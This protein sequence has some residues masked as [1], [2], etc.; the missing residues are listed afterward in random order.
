MLVVGE[1]KKIQSLFFLIPYSCNSILGAPLN[2]DGL[3][4]GK[5]P[6]PNSLL[7][8]SATMPTSCDML[9]FE[10]VF[11]NEIEELCKPVR[12]PMG[13]PLSDLVQFHYPDFRVYFTLVDLVIAMKRLFTS[14]EMFDNNNLSMIICNPDFERAPNRRAFRIQDIR[15]VLKPL[16]QPGPENSIPMPLVIPEF[17]E[18]VIIIGSALPPTSSLVDKAYP[19]CDPTHKYTISPELREAFKNNKFF[20]PDQKT[21]SLRAIKI[22]YM[23][24]YRANMT[25]LVDPR[26]PNIVLLFD[27]PLGKAFEVQAFHKIQLNKM[28]RKCIRSVYCPSW[29]PFQAEQAKQ[30]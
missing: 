25:W 11:K 21:F 7:S 9:V 26:D 13:S 15:S 28:I 30:K 17:S 14:Y 1:G 20:A 3:A 5:F 23:R 22:A 4:V 19:Y 27:D 18:S 2:G 16:V 8:I 24:Y 6:K 10:F 29:V 12:F